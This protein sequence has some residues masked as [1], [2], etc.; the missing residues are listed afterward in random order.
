M[1]RR[2][3][4]PS[5]KSDVEVGSPNSEASRRTRPAQHA[6]RSKGVPAAR[7]A[8]ATFHLEVHG[9]RMR[10]LERPTPVLVAL[11]PY[12]IDRFGHAVVGR[13]AGPPQVVQSPQDVVVP[14]AWGTK[15]RSMRP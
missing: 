5:G 10:V 8:G 4:A 11:L 2:S 9:A 6:E 14:S 1:P 12:Q 15:S 3:S 7:L 13:D